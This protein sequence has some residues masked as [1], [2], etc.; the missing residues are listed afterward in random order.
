MLPYSVRE[1]AETC[2]VKTFPLS[3]KN[4][5]Y[6]LL[7]N[8][9]SLREHLKEIEEKICREPKSPTDLWAG[10]DF[11]LPPSSE[12]LGNITWKDNSATEQGFEIEIITK[13][14]DRDSTGHRSITRATANQEHIRRTFF[15][16]YSYEVQVRAFNRWGASRSSKYVL[17]VPEE[18]L[19]EDAALLR[20]FIIKEPVD[21]ETTCFL[22]VTVKYTPVRLTGESGGVLGGEFSATLM[23]EKFQRPSGN[24]YCVFK[25]DVVG[26]RRGAWRIDILTEDNQ[27]LS[28]GVDLGRGEN[29]TIF[30]IS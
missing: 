18:N 5:F 6:V 11:H 17:Y 10:V 8:R 28:R 3:L 9:S 26:L 27:D 12:A 21:P 4:D 13:H 24:Y 23:S 16:G 14:R 2:L 30:M 20:I 7:E 29:R 22:G 25:T 15:L 19:L 1:I